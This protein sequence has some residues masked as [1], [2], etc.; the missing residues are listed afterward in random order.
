MEKSMKEETHSER[1]LVIDD[2]DKMRA[3]IAH[4]LMRAGYSCQLVSDAPYAREMLN[5][6]S[7]ELVLCDISLPG[8]SGLALAKE[9]ATQH[10]D[11]AV[12]MITAME[13]EDIADTAAEF[14]ASGH[15][16]KPFTQSQLLTTVANV[17]RR[18]SIELEHQRNPVDGGH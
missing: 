11:S 16:T 12:V 15:I 18:R 4:V 13:G 7:Y 8:G 14:G 1:V 3:T 5:Q 6:G 10:P 9:I 17:L 2:H